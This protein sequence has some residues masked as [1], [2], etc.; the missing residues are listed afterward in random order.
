MSFVDFRNKFHASAR[1]PDGKTFQRDVLSTVLNKVEEC[2]GEGGNMKK[3]ILFV[4]DEPAKTEVTQCST[5]Q[6]TTP[7]CTTPYHTRITTIIV[8][9]ITHQHITPPVITPNTINQVPKEVRNRLDT[10]WMN[11]HRNARM[12]IS[13]LQPSTLGPDLSDLNPVWVQLS[14]GSLTDTD[15]S[16]VLGS[17][18]QT[19]DKQWL[20]EL[21]AHSKP[22]AF[23]LYLLSSVGS[24][25]RARVTVAELMKIPPKSA[26]HTTTDVLQSTRGVLKAIDF[27]SS[28][29]CPAKICNLAVHELLIHVVLKKKIHLNDD[30]SKFGGHSAQYWLLNAVLSNALPKPDD[31]GFSQVYEIPQFPMVIIHNWILYNIK[32]QQSV[33]K[34]KSKVIYLRH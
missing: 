11:S 8:T 17:I 32:L 33:T 29:F 24:N 26:L 31:T 5:P 4:V 18:A 25:W 27:V 15:L 1:N 34:Q 22:R 3:N 7:H 2:L 12:V 19:S 28:K 16:K 6:N 13:S 9:S 30:K 21:L 23:A 10:H 14:N 20:V